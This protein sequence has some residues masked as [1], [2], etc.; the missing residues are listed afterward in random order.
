MHVYEFSVYLEVGVRKELELVTPEIRA[1]SIAEKFANG[2]HSFKDMFVM[3]MEHDGDTG[4]Q[5]DDFRN[6]FQKKT[7]NE[8]YDVFR[9][10]SYKILASSKKKIIGNEVVEYFNTYEFTFKH[11]R[12]E[13][14]ILMVVSSM[15]AIK[16][17]VSEPRSIKYVGIAE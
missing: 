11:K 12:V 9:L 17:R 1:K 14:P 13:Y 3:E 15:K 4:V 10:F 2:L 5:I 16:N 6:N 8:E 7:V